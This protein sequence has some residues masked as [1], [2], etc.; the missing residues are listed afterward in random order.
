MKSTEVFE[1]FE[2]KIPITLTRENI[3]VHPETHFKH[4]KWFSKR[5]TPG[6]ESRGDQ[7]RER[8]YQAMPFS[9]MSL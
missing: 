3:A 9:M 1:P 7:G 4:F 8:L 2:V 5:P 6:G